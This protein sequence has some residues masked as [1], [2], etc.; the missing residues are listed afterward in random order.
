MNDPIGTEAETLP[1]AERHREPLVAYFSMEIALEPE[2]PTY[3]GGLGVLA[4]DTIRA[5]AD[6]R[7][8]MVAVS[9]LHRK[10]FFRQRLDPDGSQSED[11]V[12]WSVADHLEEMRPRVT[13]SIGG[14]P[15]QLR[16]WKYKAY[17]RDDF[18]VPVY[19]LDADLPENDPWHRTLTDH[20][21]GGDQTYRLCQEAIL[22]IGGVRMLRA[23]GYTSC[24][25][26]HMNE[27]HA[28][29]LTL[30]LL[31][32]QVRRAG[33]TA[34][35]PDDIEAVRRLCCFTT[36]TPVVAGH[37]Q[38]PIGLVN[39]FL[40]APAAIREMGDPAC[41]EYAER[42]MGRPP[43]PSQAGDPPYADGTLNMTLL[44]LNLSHY[45]NGVAKR[46]GEV[47]RLM[48]TGYSIDAITN[49]VHAATW[50]APSFQALFDRH[51]P[52]WREDNS[53]LRYALSIPMPEI[54]R[55]HE[56]A[57]QALTDLVRRQTGVALDQKALTIGFAR[58][59]AT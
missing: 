45:V 23:L 17:G 49:G 38:F 8:P 27:G 5:A 35:V 47:S 22:G 56:V 31:D 1:R 36:H 41:V 42:V 37:D 2:I 15:V 10:G 46:H 32:E 7:T 30:E 44:A 21:Y 40:E 50:T 54:W 28:A 12:E 24:G 52:G 57:K 43:E 26:F 18:Y 16:A 59:A 13:L 29:L 9:L 55:A 3:S 4:G 25:R 48:F 34:I 51:I 14:Q 20:L 53:S 33:R 19:L 39:R 6:L 58:R 11:P